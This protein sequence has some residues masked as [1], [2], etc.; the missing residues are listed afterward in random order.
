M[1][2]KILLNWRWEKT[3][4][5]VKRALKELGFYGRCPFRGLDG[6]PLQMEYDNDAI[7]PGCLCCQILDG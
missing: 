4:A 7:I 3:S 6:L 2:M 5:Y 1:S